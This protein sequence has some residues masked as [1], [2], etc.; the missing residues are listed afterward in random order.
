[1][2]KICQSPLPQSTLSYVAFRVA[3]RQT[4]DEILAQHEAVGTS[5]NSRGYLREVSFL[6]EVAPAVQLELLASTWHKHVSREIHQS[7]LVDE[8][9]IYAACE[10]TA[11]LVESRRE[12]VIEALAGGPLDLTLPLDAYF[13]RELRLLYLELPSQGDFLLVNQF[14]DLDPEMAIDC[15]LQMGIDPQRMTP[16]FDALGRWRISPQMSKWLRG[17][18]TQTETALVTSNLSRYLAR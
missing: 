5:D 8:S 11:R 13:A 9:V 6:Q 7:D 3:F 15:K 2:L 10:T 14:L 1:M 12:Y 4:F 16:L 18:L 17:L